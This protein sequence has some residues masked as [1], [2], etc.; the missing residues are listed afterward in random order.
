ML[1][2]RL[3]ELHELHRERL[4]FAL[5]EGE[6][7]ADQRAQDQCQEEA[8]EARDPPDD[9]AGTLALLLSRKSPRR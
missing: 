1:R 6:A 7:R 9:A 8:Q 4:E 3:I 2:Q 5:K